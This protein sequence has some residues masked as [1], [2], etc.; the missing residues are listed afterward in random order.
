M[1]YRR[2]EGRGLKRKN[3]GW[4]TKEEGRSKSKDKEGKKNEG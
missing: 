2:G 1:K 4:R 3:G